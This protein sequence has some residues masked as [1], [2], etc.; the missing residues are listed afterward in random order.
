M[1]KLFY[2]S[3]AL[4]FCYFVVITFIQLLK[5]TQQSKYLIAHIATVCCFVFTVLYSLQWVL[6]NQ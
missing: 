4:T 3:V 5:E 1:L 6:H 2:L